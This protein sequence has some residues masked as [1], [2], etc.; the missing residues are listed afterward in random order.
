[1]EKRTKYR[2]FMSQCVGA[3]CK[4]SKTSCE[5]KE[6]DATTGGSA[7]GSKECDL[8]ERDISTKGDGT[9][10]SVSIFST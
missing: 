10:N 1:M 5:A 7:L 8:R 6:T 2:R 4:T 9:L 3:R